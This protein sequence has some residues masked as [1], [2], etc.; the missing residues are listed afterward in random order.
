MQMKKDDVQWL[1]ALLCFALFAVLS[2]SAFSPVYA[3]AVPGGT[4]DPLSIPKYVTPLVIPPEMPKSTS[5]PAP[6][7]DYDIAVRQFKQQI[8]PGGIWGP[9]FPNPLSGPTGTVGPFPATTIWS[10]GRAQ[11]PLPDSSGIG[12]AVG[13][14]PAMNSSFNYPAFTVENTTML[15]TKV[16]WI[17]DL[18]DQVSGNYLSHLFNVDQTLH[19][20][21]PPKEHCVMMP[22]DRTDCETSVAAPYSGPVP[23]VT[24]VHG[25]HVQPHSDGYP[26]AW[27]L[28]GAPGTKGI[29]ASYAERGSHYTQADNANTVAGSAFY[30][31][32][33]TQAATTLWYHDHALGMT[34][35]NVY[36]GPAGF[37]LI[38]GG[39]YDKATGL[40]GPAPRA[41]D[42]DPNFS[43]AVRAAVREVPIAIQDRSFNSDGS[44][45]YPADRTF[46]DGFTGP[47][48]GGAG[49][50][51]GPSD[52]SG[53]WNP[54]AFFNTMVVNGT[55]WP[56]FEVAPA[57]YRLRLLNGCNSRTLNLS[58]STVTSLGTDII[59]G[60][61]DDVYGAGLPAGG[62]QDPDR[63]I[64][65]ASRR[66]HHSGARSG[67]GSVA[68]PADGPGG[69][70]RRDRRF[71]RFAE[72]HSH[73][74]DQYSA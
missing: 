41:A 27:W 67:S 25:A 18:V 38:R 8:L 58:M 36:A 46:F 20:A 35:L 52:M 70:G 12:G 33:N 73:P 30:N 43:A 57:R 31:Y 48:I 60:T 68:G 19:W 69:T 21:N 5:S 3:Q 50:P 10:Y 15:P 72:R 39:A 9:V 55:T 22:D 63:S 37:W 16:R 24:H 11:D 53:I 54:E 17:N 56:K 47:Y 44:L 29:P 59:P 2:T 32:E 40:P 1:A 49:T 6:A 61:A 45:F 13:V 4:L 42:G 62:C 51:S 71:H 65:G 7:A 66:R 34:R 26:E 64:H 74:H 14:A 28:P 23:L